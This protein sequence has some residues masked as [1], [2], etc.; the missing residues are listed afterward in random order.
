MFSSDDDSSLEALEALLAFRNSITS[1]ASPPR[2]HP[3]I[4]V[5]DPLNPLL[6]HVI[7]G[8]STPMLRSNEISTRPQMPMLHLSV[9]SYSVPNPLNSLATSSVTEPSSTAM[10]SMQHH[11]NDTTEQKKFFNTTADTS[12][13]RDTA[14]EPPVTNTRAVCTDKIKDALNSRP[15][16]GKKRRNLNEQERLELTR[17]RNREHAKCTR[18]VP[19]CY[20]SNVLTERILNWYFVLHR[21]KK[22][23]RHLE[24]VQMEKMYLVMKAKHDLN[25][26]RKTRVAKIIE[27]VREAGDHKEMKPCPHVSRLRSLS[28][29]RLQHAQMSCAGGPSEDEV[30]MSGSH[31]ATVKVSVSGTDYASGKC[32]NIT[33]FCCVDFEAHSAEVSS[34]SLHWVEQECHQC[35][36]FPS[37]SAL[38]FETS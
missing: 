16:R 12:S 8:D 15:Q 38:S 13:A 19:I 32:E 31:S 22:K 6:P 33:A 1:Y 36:M 34:I 20:D 5:P 9:S 29:E 4:P 35:K 2:V 27:A 7:E 10:K 30:A 11:S 21:L 23:A 18:Y 26:A 28:A 37:I 24:L 25:A 17:T 3:E 14:T